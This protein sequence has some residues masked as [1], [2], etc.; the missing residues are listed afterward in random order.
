MIC[1]FTQGAE[2]AFD[3]REETTMYKQAGARKTREQSSMGAKG[4]LDFFRYEM[5]PYEYQNVPMMVTTKAP[6]HNIFGPKTEGSHVKH[7]C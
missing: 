4:R 3:R 7:K 6:C 2:K 5:I 1:F